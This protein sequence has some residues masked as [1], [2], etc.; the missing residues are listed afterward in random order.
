VMIAIEIL[1]ERYQSCIQ[2]DKEPG[3]QLWSVSDPYRYAIII[4]TSL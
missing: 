1:K 4:D 3:V 2:E